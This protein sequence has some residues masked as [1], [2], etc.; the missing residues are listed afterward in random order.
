M[1]GTILVRQFQLLP[2]TE[3]HKRRFRNIPQFSQTIRNF[4]NNVSEMKKLAAR[5]YKDVLQVRLQYS[6][7]CYVSHRRRL[8][9]F[10]P[11]IRRSS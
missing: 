8:L 4:T 9:V 11:S 5:D 3:T 1:K 2:R 10:N 7:P 6:E